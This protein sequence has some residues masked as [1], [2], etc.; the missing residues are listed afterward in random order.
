MPNLTI[1]TRGLACPLPILKVRKAM[2]TVPAGAEVEVLATDPGSIEDLRAFCAAT[3]NTFLHFEQ[4]RD[5]A[6]QFL[7]RKQ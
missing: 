6:L 7:I 1:D 5:G 4:A 2:R 3:G